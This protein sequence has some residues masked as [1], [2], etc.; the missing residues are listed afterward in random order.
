MAGNF[1]TVEEFITWTDNPVNI[2]SPLYTFNDSKESV[3]EL[4]IRDDYDR[5]T[6]VWKNNVRTYVI[7][8]GVVSYA[9]TDLYITASDVLTDIGWS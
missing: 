7:K 5:I 3:I 2:N 9:V 8:V 4:N 1:T 6:V